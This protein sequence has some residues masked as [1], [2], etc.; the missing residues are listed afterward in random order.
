MLYISQKT[1]VPFRALLALL[2][3]LVCVAVLLERDR[4]KMVE[5]GRARN[6]RL[7][8]LVYWVVA[9]SGKPTYIVAKIVLN[10]LTNKHL[11]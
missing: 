6:Y 10:V 8:F 4:L 9:L 2:Y 1:I 5:N 3:S 11:Y 7:L